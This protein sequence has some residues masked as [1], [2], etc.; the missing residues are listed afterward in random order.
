[1]TVP[2][3]FANATGLVPANELDVNFAYVSNNVSTAN[4]VVFAAQTNITSVGT[5]TNLSVAGNVTAGRL[6]GEGGNISNIQGANISGTVANA[7]YAVTANSSSYSTNSI[8]ANI[9]NIANLVTGGNVSGQVANALIAGTVYTNSQPNITSV[10]TLTSL[11]SSGNITGANLTTGGQVS[12]TGNVTGGNIVTNG[13]VSA[14]GNVRGSNI[15]TVGLMTATGNV[16][17]GNILTNGEV[18]AVGNISTSANVLASGYMSITG[19]IDTGGLVSA[20][21]NISTSLNMLASGRVDAL[22]NVRGGNVL[23]VGYVSAT[24]NVTAANVN[25]G[26][27]SA[28]G[29]IITAGYFVGNFAGNITG[30]LVVPGSNTQV[31]FNNQGNAGAT[32]GLTFDTAGPNL[33]TINGNVQ[34]GNLLTAG[35]ISATA[36]ITAGNLSGTNIVGTLTT[37]SQT[38]ITSVGTLGSLSVTGNINAGNVIATNLSGPIF[39]AYQTTPQNLSTGTA[40]LIYDTATVNSSNYYDPVTGIFTPLVPGYYQ[41]N[42]TVLPTPGSTGSFFL[43]LFKNGSAFAQGTGVAVQATWGQSGVSS[44]SVTVPFNGTTD[45]INCKIIGTSVVGAWTTTP[46]VPAYFQACWIRGI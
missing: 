6:K 26:N 22:G 41:V 23:T 19:N 1:M 34:A 18:S 13:T 39:L 10:G 25:V 36:N 21:G 8:Q 46:G 3:T 28:T 5:L 33:L 27:V 17:G 15:N 32:A 38:N 7:T 45:Y 30:N 37:A 31:L 2:Y 35:L 4:T 44:V 40:N 24:G 29:N 14:T 11:S 12:A 42:A 9:A 43:G 16:T 20:V